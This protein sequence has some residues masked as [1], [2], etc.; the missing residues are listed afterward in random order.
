MNGSR[1]NMASGA[2][3]KSD[4]RDRV[5]NLET[6]RRMVPLV[7]RIVADILAR[8]HSLD[9]LLPEQ[10]RLDRTKRSLAWPERRR[11]YQVREDVAQ[12]E[13]ALEAAGAELQELGV[14]LLD[15]VV[16]RVGF[17]TVVN[18]KAA[19]FSW[20]SG[21]EGVNGWHF[22]NETRSRPIPPAW[23]KIGDPTLT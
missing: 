2:P 5:M 21:Q 6:A 18:E 7:Q 10:E 3:E 23:N 15:P 19:F 14:A 4:W 1:E 20:Q 17:P 13:L 16:G 22:A 11:R 9:L 8:Q 12:A